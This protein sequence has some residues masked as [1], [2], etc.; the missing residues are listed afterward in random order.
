M[1]LIGKKGPA[2]MRDLKIIHL[3]KRKA[4]MTYSY[5]LLVV[6]AYL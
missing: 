6:G 1:T 5:P 2:Q 4:R 3:N